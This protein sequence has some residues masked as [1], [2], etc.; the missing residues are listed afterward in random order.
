MRLKVNDSYQLRLWVES[1]GSW[2]G[3]PVCKD[4]AP[5]L[6]GLVFHVNGTRNRLQVHGAGPFSGVA[7][8]LDINI[9]I[10]DPI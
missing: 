10:Q 1:E 8:L 9:G 2:F 6:F 3:P 7:M 4:F 5:V